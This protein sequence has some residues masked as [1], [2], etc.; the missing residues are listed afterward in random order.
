MS[1]PASEV[2]FNFLGNQFRGSSDSVDLFNWP[3]FTTTPFGLEY[4]NGSAGGIEPGRPDAFIATLSTRMP[5]IPQ[6][7]LDYVCESAEAFSRGLYLG[8]SVLSGIAAEA[9]LQDLYTA[10]AQHMEPTKRSAYENRLQAN[11][12]SADKRFGISKGN[13]TDHHAELDPNLV[14]RLET[15]LDP[16]ARMLSEP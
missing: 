12:F 10:L 3:F 5:T 1:Y 16:L 14:L 4:L 11:K 6:I 2:S 9:L 13:L 7:A 8:T 15:L